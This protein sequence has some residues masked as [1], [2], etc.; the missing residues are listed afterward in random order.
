MCLVQTEVWIAK[1]I[2]PETL[3]DLR[4]EHEK[5]NVKD[6]AGGSQKSS[7]PGGNAARQPQGI[8]SSGQELQSHEMQ[9]RETIKAR[10]AELARRDEKV[11][12]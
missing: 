7:D 11:S 9:I 2:L 1:G 6:P 12:E 5:E 10:Q 3:C 8:D 4:S